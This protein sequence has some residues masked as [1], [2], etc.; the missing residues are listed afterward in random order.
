MPAIDRLCA[1]DLSELYTS[2]LTDKTIAANE[3]RT[4]NN[5]LVFPYRNLKG[6]VNGFYRRKPHKPRLNKDGEPIKYEQPRAVPP[7]PYYPKGSL[8]KLIDGRSPIFVTEG[9]KKALALSQLDLAAIGLG[10]VYGWKSKD[11]E[12]LIADLAQIEWDGRD[13]YVV[14][15]YDE[16]PK[17]RSDDGSE[18]C[19]RA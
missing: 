12:G 17:T 10:G 19:R 5:A 13:V 11:I 14:F 16:K 9:E 1:N 7:R 18:D 4:K 3:I 15:D 6:E 8:A 2:G